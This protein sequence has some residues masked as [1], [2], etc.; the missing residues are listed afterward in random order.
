MST[1]HANVK[2]NS[3]FVLNWLAQFMKLSLRLMR[4][5][6]GL[7][8]YM[9]NIKLTNNVEVSDNKEIASEKVKKKNK[10]LRNY[11]VVTTF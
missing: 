2:K 9:T 11:I 8:Q 10:S 5:K 6:L 3:S 4:M 7:Y 1:N